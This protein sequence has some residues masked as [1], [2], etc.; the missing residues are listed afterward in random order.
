MNESDRTLSISVEDD[1]YVIRTDQLRFCVP[2]AQMDVVVLT[3]ANL[4]LSLS[5]DGRVVIDPFGVSEDVID[6][7]T[8][9]TALPSPTLKELVAK[10]LDPDLV[11]MEDDPR[12]SVADLRAE[13]LSCLALADAAA[14]RF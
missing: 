9:A 5:L 1:G 10:A 13:L 2:D 11:Q 3:K 14:N 6:A 7:V 4:N 12:Q 8:R